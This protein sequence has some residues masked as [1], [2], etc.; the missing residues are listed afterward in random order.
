ME[1]PPHEVH[2]WF[3]TIDVADQ[4][5]SLLDDSEQARA[6]RYRFE[7][8]RRRS[9]AARGLL[10]SL[11]ASYLGSDARA[12]RFVEGEHGKPSLA[13]DGDLEL[14]ASHSGDL[15]ALAFTRGTAVG[16]DVERVRS[17]RDARE[18]S[19]RFFSPR[20]VELVRAAPDIDATFFTIWTAKEAVVKA[21]GRGIGASLQSFAVPMDARA[22]ERVL[23]WDE[24]CVAHV[25]AP[26][27]GY[28]AAVSVASEARSREIVVRRW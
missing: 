26:L 22:F 2:V 12:L 11:A 1:L 5:A 4:V 18:V 28:R 25:D 3:A 23:G 21:L 14:N 10:R 24:W 17:M 27:D 6:A 19:Q 20:E 13:G 7:E 9:I 16:V 8:D 15:V